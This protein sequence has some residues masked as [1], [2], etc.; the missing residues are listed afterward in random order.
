MKTL[1]ATVLALACLTSCHSWD[2]K[3]GTYTYDDAVRELGP[4][5]A[6]KELPDG[7]KVYRWEDKQLSKMDGEVRT[8]DGYSVLLTFG[9][10][11]RL[12]KGDDE[13]PAL[14]RK[15]AI[16]WDLAAAYES[17]EARAYSLTARKHGL[18]V[19]RVVNIAMEGAMEGWSREP[20]RQ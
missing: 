12:R 16:Y 4:P 17:D 3:V 20:P 8:S 9:R 14:A 11:D 18:S 15:K 2:D 7:G 1:L 6:E 19:T 5:D 13:W 10:D